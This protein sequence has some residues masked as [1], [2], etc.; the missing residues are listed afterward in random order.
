MNI[1]AALMGMAGTLALT[2]FAYGQEALNTTGRMLEEDNR[3]T[4]GGYAQ[5]DYNQS[6]SSGIRQNG[7]LDVHRMVLLFG[8]KFNPKTQFISEVEFEHVEEV[9][10][11]QAFLQY[12]IAP[13]IKFRGGLMLVPMGIINEFH[14]PP[15]FHG[16]ERP[17][18]DTYIVPT[19]WREIGAG[20]TGVF[21]SVRLSYQM[22][23]MNGF[24]SY[25]DNPN[26]NG[27]SGFRKG[28]QKGAG[29][30]I[31]SPNLAFRLNYFGLSG[32]QLGLSYAGGATQS[33]LYHGI[34]KSNTRAIASTDSSV[35]T[36]HMMGLDARYNLGGLQ[37]RAQAN[38]GAISNS[39]AYNDFTGSDIGS[40]IFGWYGE[41][42]YDVFSH[43]ERTES[44]LIPFIRY[45][46][47][48]THASVE[49]GMDANPLYNRVDITM[50]IGW[51]MAQGAIIKLDYQIFKNKGPEESRGQF[52]AGI[53]VWF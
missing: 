17:N 11:E 23:L 30:L 52:N 35:V 6:M 32:L 43:I 40:A 14:E 50:G 47:Y 37:I 16:V 34:E 31:S 53:G 28:R 24:M 49:N 46:N 44:A 13:W 22:Y 12:E 8:Y 7:T 21:T 26:L 15:A 3:L 19:T 4:I 20:F 9:Y 25:D 27:E 10:V 42:A 2:L 38:Y 51:K 29:S 5:V 39:A 1:K 18:L 48:N 33:E 36:M 41:L 45:E